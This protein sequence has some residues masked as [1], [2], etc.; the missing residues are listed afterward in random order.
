MVKFWFFKHLSFNLVHHSIITSKLWCCIEYLD[1]TISL[2][3]GQVTSL[4]GSVEWTCCPQNGPDLTAGDEYFHKKD[5]QVVVDCWQ[6]WREGCQDVELNQR[7]LI[8]LTLF[9]RRAWFNYLNGP[10]VKFKKCSE[11][12]SLLFKPRLE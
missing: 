10:P 5:P 11:P 6:L 8:T 3:F 1:N 12:Y 4:K 9:K 2:K 7:L